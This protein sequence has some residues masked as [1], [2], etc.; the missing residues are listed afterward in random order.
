MIYDFM[1]PTDILVLG[2]GFD[3]HCGL[4]SSFKDYFYAEFFDVNKKP[5]INKIIDNIWNLIFYYAFIIKKTSGNQLIDRVENDEP[6]WM[7][8][9]GYIRNVFEIQLN[10]MPKIGIFDLINTA[11]ISDN[12]SWMNT[13]VSYTGQG[14]WHLDGGNKEQRYNIYQLSLLLKEKYGYKKPEELLFGELKRFESD[15]SKYL[16]VEVKNK[17]QLYDSNVQKFIL[18]DVDN[19]GSRDLF[20]ISFNYTN[21]FGSSVKSNNIDNIHGTLKED[22]IIIGIDTSNKQVMKVAEI[23]SKIDRRMMAGLNGLTLPAPKTIRDVIFYGCSLGEQDYSYFSFIFDKYGLGT[24]DVRFIFLYSNFESEK[25]KN[26][27]NKEKYVNSVKSLV[28][29]YIQ[30]N[31][32]GQTITNLFSDRKIIIDELI[33]F[34]ENWI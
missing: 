26:E 15:F 25:A 33:H 19:Y 34:K 16:R 5:I 12:N 23:F 27:K 3:K 30:K 17:Q 10:L 29:Y 31:K 20:V 8:V 7:D 1:E 32:S 21:E 14:V 13:S 9:E 22:N 11:L 24:S 18:S 6:L 28:D 2:N 4:A